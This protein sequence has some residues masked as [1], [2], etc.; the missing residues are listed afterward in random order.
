MIFLDL[1]QLFDIQSDSV[2]IAMNDVNNVI[3]NNFDYQDQLLKMYSFLIRN[4]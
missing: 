4:V 3:Y 1:T 2:L